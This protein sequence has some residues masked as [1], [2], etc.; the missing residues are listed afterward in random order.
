M[1]SPN[2][3]P[4]SASVSIRSG[5]RASPGPISSSP[6]S[7]PAFGPSPASPASS[8]PTATKCRPSGSSPKSKPSSSTASWAGCRRR[9]AATGQASL[10]GVDP[11]TRFYTLWRY[12]YRAADLDAGEA[13]IF[14]NGTHVELD[15]PNG[16]SSGARAL[17]EK[18]KG[19]YR[20]RDL[21]RARRRRRPRPADRRRPGR[22]ADRRAPP[23]AVADGTPAAQLADFLREAAAEP[24]TDAPRGPGPGRSR[25]QG[26]RDGRRLADRRDGGPGQAD[27]PTGGASS[28][29]TCLTRTRA[30]RPQDAA[31][32]GL[33]E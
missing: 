20:L 29:T 32:R 28:K 14:A 19:K 9:S 15:G 31:R 1:S 2:W 10:A 6:A 22:P 21:R 27:R 13:I 7:V 30:G 18:K 4:S 17:V 5:T 11:A 33:F 24:R 16:L 3:K 8:T 12:T 26:R 25:P 23:N